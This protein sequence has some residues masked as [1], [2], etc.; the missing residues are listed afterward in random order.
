MHA[1]DAQCHIDVV[2][3]YE[4]PE[5]DSLAVQSLLTNDDFKTE[6]QALCQVDGR[7]ET[8]RPK[9]QR[10]CHLG[11]LPLFLLLKRTE[12]MTPAESAMNRCS[13]ELSEATVRRNNLYDSETWDIRPV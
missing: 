5:D 2:Q 11:R 8:R 10:N 4:I 9:W 1:D 6:S 7:G 13:W 3:S 12:T